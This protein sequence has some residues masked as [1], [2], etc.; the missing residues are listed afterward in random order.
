MRKI[1]AV[2]KPT[3][4]LGKH[5][6]AEVEKERKEEELGHLDLIRRAKLNLLAEER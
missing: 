3:T 6:S 2:K 4:A 1:L 5:G